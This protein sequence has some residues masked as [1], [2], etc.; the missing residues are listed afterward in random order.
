M[1]LLE[2]TATIA[3][4]EL[5]A[6]HVSLLIFD[7]VVPPS[8]LLL[9]N[10]P[11]LYIRW[12]GISKGYQLGFNVYKMLKLENFK[13]YL[14]FYGS[15]GALGLGVLISY[16]FLR[17]QQN[18]MFYAI[19]FVFSMFSAYF[20]YKWRNSFYSSVTF[21]LICTILIGILLENI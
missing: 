8:V 10:I 3:E 16:A 17:Y 15:L 4:D 1:W 9:Y 21:S 19:L 2:S 11:H 18:N 13:K 5:P 20:F 7:H 6:F 12:E 14:K